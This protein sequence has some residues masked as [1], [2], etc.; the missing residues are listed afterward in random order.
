MKKKPAPSPDAP[1]RCAIYTRKSTTHGLDQEFNSLDAQREACAAYIKRQP[2]WTL[3]DEHYDDGGF[4]G[5]NIERPAFQRL[6]ADVEAG[7]LDVVV[8]YKVDRLSRSLLD[9]AK[10]MERLDKAHASFVSVTQNF[11]TA[12][13]MGRLTM[14]L[15][16]SFAEFEREMISER[17]RDKIA[18]TRRKGLWTGGP[19]PLGYRVENKKLII[20]D[21]EAPVVR[22]AF[23]LFLAHGRMS[24]VASIMNERGRFPRKTKRKDK[25]P[26]WSK[27]TMAK[28]LRN[29]IYG[30]VIAYFDERHA[31]EHQPIIDKATF[32]RAQ[33]LLKSRSRNLK[34]HGLNFDY[35][36]RGLLKC[37]KCKRPMIPASTR[38]GRQVYR[39]YKCSNRDKHGRDECDAA[40]LAARAIET[41]VIERIA[42]AAD[43][44]NLRREIEQAMQKRLKAKEAEFA[45]VKSRA[46]QL[47]AMHSARA[48]KLV[49]ELTQLEGRAR[50]VAAE[51]LS[52]TTEEL[53]AAERSLAE[54]EH[55]ER[56]VRAAMEEFGP[57][58]D[59][60]KNFV[61]VWAVMTPANRVRFMG[62]LIEEVVVD[63]KKG[64][65]SISMVDFE[66]VVAA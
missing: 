13:A 18:A 14:N 39:Y 2:N 48:S 27:D 46:P 55:G 30:G 66:S 7:K 44:K 19:R 17:T 65:V 51:N 32:E 45:T 62:A 54:A 41:Y 36:L 15:L 37:G 60:L 35:V 3:V 58:L 22:E 16:A 50:D 43:S 49:D 53:A 28:L 33:H 59:S 10:V 52:A 57:V 47:I 42:E 29:P 25:Q 38:K 24:T 26:K 61:E 31:G 5:A 21:V 9:F 8:V 20:D 34:F 40:P 64:E 11:S 12:D 1:R 56:E 4:T 63:D 23:E 6:M